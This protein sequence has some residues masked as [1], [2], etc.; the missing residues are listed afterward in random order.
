MSIGILLVIAFSSAGAVVYLL[1]Y[2]PLVGRIGRKTYS[3]RLLVCKILAPFDALATLL[4]IAGGWFGIS[5][6]VG[7]G[8]SI[9]NI[10][11]G[12]GISVGVIIVK[13]LMVP[14]WTKKYEQEVE[15][16]EA[17]TSSKKSPI[18]LKPATK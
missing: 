14:R 1:T 9:M 15:G 2:V 10:L 4:L 17:Q 16:F 11:T 18:V 12:I 3:P 13:K 5:A 8:A 7:L 6:A